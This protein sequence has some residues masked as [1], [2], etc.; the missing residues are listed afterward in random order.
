MFYSSLPIELD[1]NT[2]NGRNSRFVD[3]LKFWILNKYG[4]IYLDLDTWPIKPLSDLCQYE[5]V[6]VN[7]VDDAYDLF[8]IGIEKG[9]VFDHFKMQKSGNISFYTTHDIERSLDYRPYEFLLKMYKVRNS[10]F[11]Q[12][13]A[14]GTLKIGDK[15]IIDNVM[16]NYYIDHIRTHEWEN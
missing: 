15:L 7:F 13:F 16:P 4:G 14:A 11:M 10:R 5:S 8:M 12:N 2:K 1:I 6:G 3:C 9:K